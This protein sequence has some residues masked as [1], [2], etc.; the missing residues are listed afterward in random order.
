MNLNDLIADISN[1]RDKIEEELS[2]LDEHMA[3]IIKARL[4]KFV[5]LQTSILESKDQQLAEMKEHY[6]KIRMS[7]LN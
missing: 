6:E 4:T 5:A 1:T 3:Q 2:K 7:Q